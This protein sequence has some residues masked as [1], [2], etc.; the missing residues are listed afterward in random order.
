[1]NYWLTLTDIRNGKCDR[2]I[3][4]FVDGVFDLCHYGH[5]KLFE[6]VK[7]ALAPYEVF[8]IAGVHY[9]EEMESIKRRSVMS[10]EERIMAVKLSPFV[11]QVLTAPYAP[12]RHFF[13]DHRIDL[14]AHDPS[15]LSF[16]GASDMYQ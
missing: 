11:D 9:D 10:T 16:G 4:V 7:T 14:L 13:D 8:L 6:K 3:R 1:M 15:P 5:Y 12:E 2:P